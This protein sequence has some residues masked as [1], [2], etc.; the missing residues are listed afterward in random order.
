MRSKDDVFVVMEKIHP[1]PVMFS[2]TFQWMLHHLDSVLS[3]NMM[4]GLS[5]SKHGF[6]EVTSKTGSETEIDGIIPVMLAHPGKL[7]DNFVSSDAQ[8]NTA[9]N[10]ATNEM[11]ESFDEEELPK[12]SAMQVDNDIDDD[13]SQ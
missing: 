4:L 12:K 9:A 13:W 7:L 6:P 5:D 1:A 2:D 8:S 3:Q 11:T 10:S